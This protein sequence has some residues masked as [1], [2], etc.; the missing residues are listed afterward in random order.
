MKKLALSLLLLLFAADLQ[1]SEQQLP[2][3]GLRVNAL[4]PLYPGK[5]YRL[6]YRLALHDQAA[7]RTEFIVGLGV[8]LPQNRDT[9]GRFSEASGSFAVRQFIDQAWHIELMTAYGQGRL[10]DHVTTG[11]NYRSWDLELM[12]LLGYEWRLAKSW[13]L[14]LQAGAGK[15]V[16]KSNPWPIYEDNTLQKEIGEV[17]FPVGTLHLTYWLCCR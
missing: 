1:A 16:Q 3:Q 14:D 2:E 17:L 6:A 13:S 10:D 4:W 15:I 11:L 5:K 12:G 9:E 7:Y 8:S